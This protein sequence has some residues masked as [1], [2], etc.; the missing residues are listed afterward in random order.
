MTDNYARIV[1]AN[2][3]RLD[4]G[5]PD[6]LSE[7]LPARRE[8]NEW[9]FAAFGRHCRLSRDGITLDGRPEQGVMGILISLYALHAGPAPLVL[10]PL[11]AYRDFEGSAPYAA[12]FARH[13]EKILEPHAARL[14]AHGGRLR[15][16]FQGDPTPAGTP[17]DA[18]FVVRPL[19]KIALCYI[20]YAA[21]EEFPAAATCLF[22]SNA[23][24]FLPL[25]ALADVGEYTS[26]RLIQLADTG[27]LE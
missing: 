25:D 16:A 21:D 1:Q 2:L 24:A 17:G 8:K 22:S 26:R 14:M 9:L 12:A 10:A 27:T 4:P 3:E 20:L 15:Q 6:R 5:R 19:P 23:D 13:T 7:C 11:R 18:A